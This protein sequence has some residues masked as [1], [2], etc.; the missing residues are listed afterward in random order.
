MTRSA[1]L[2]K[3]FDSPTSSGDT[4][5]AESFWRE[6]GIIADIRDDLSRLEY[7]PDFIDLR[8]SIERIARGDL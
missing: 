2:M 7:L 6:R 3:I 4:E 1:S 8:E 5:L